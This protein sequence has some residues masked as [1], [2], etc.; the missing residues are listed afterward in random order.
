VIKLRSISAFIIIT[1]IGILWAIPLYVLIIG[2][3]K[4]VR[5]VLT[6]PIFLPP[7]K[8]NLNTFFITIDS[9]LEALMNTS[10]EVLPAAT[11]SAILGSL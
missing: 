8:P 9:M 10:L 3:L 4:D 7:S 5:E 2:S 11:I 6:T 1:V